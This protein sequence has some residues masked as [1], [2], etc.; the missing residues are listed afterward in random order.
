MDYSQLR[1]CDLAYLGDSVLELLTRSYLVKSGVT[2][3]GELNKKSLDFVTAANQ[4]DAFDRIED[5]LTETELDVYKR[6]RNN[7]KAAVPKSVSVMQ[8]RKATGLEALFAYLF[9]SGQ[10]DRMK[11][12]FDKAFNINN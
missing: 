3:S 11:I 4:A 10:Y 6:A 1:S 7:S 8:Y 2:G 5:I 9:L 12:L